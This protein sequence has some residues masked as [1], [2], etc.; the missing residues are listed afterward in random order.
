MLNIFVTVYRYM[1]NRVLLTE[2]R[3]KVLTG[4]YD[5]SDAALRNQKSR[6]RESSKTVLDELI[7]VAESPEIDNRDVFDPDDVF[8]LL[9]AIMTPR[10][11]DLEPD[12]FVNVVT[13]DKQNAEFRA[14]TD[15]LY[16]QMDKLMHPYRDS[17]FPDPDS[18]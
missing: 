5:G 17:R 10:Q 1:G 7:Q 6:L 4:E 8:R 16:I 3:E 2:K 12:E 11:E 13:V 15:R 18:E 14:Y 9:R